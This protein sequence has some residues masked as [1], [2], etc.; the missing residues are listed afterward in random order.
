MKQELK[1]LS[2]AV[3][4]YEEVM[5]LFESE[6]Q[7]HYNSMLEEYKERKNALELSRD[8]KADEYRFINAIIQA[9]TASGSGSISPAAVIGVEREL[10]ALNFETIGASFTLDYW[11]KSL[12]EGQLLAILGEILNYFL[13][14]FQV[15]ENLTDIQMGQIALKLMSSQPNLRIRELVYVL[16]SALKG[17]YGPTYQRIG[18]DTILGWLSK[19]YEQSA[20]YLELKVTNSRKEE[21]RGESP[22]LEMDKKLKAY[23]KEQREKKVIN[24]RVWQ[25]EKRDLAVEKHKTEMGL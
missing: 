20:E 24:D 6:Y 4:P 17:E 14:Q 21:S 18:I 11:R 10:A 13:S 25:Q 2:G 9:N 19:F 16:N 22:W 8:R 1:N 3:K 23:E 12:S 7:V 15:K 5:R